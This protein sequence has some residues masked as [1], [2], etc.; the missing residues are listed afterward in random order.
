MEELA[1]TEPAKQEHATAFV[2]LKC[3]RRKEGDVADWL[4]KL[5]KGERCGGQCY[6][7][8]KPGKDAA[9]C[10]NVRI[11]DAAYSFGPFDFIITIQA[12]DVGE[13]EEFIVRC[14]R[15]SAKIVLDTQ[16][17]V[18]IPLKVRQQP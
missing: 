2:L 14:L 6:F 4:L 3:D 18:G 13:I 8:G 12:S 7:H 16:T 9:Y 1:A 11:S 10:Q 15:S 5:R 17:L